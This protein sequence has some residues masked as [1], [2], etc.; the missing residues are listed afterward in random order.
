MRIIACALTLVIGLAH[1]RAETGVG[2]V[3]AGEPTKQATVTSH[4]KAWLRDH[5]YAVVA[6]PFDGEAS[7]TFVN[8][9]VIEDMACARGVFEKRVHAATVIYARVELQAKGSLGLT[10]Y[11]FVKDHDAAA[12]K[13]SCKKCND[14]Q[15]RK[16]IDAALKT[17]VKSSGL[18]KGRLVLSSTPDGVVVEIDTVRVGVTPIERDLEPGSHQI[19]LLQGGQQVGAKAVTIERGETAELTIPVVIP[20]D[21]VPPKPITIEKTKIVEKTKVVVVEKPQPPSRVLP[22]VIMFAGLATAAGGGV[23][24]YYG[25]K[26]GPD[27]PWLYPK[28]TRNGEI[29]AGAGGA[30]FVI[31]TIWF[32]ARSG[33]PQE[34]PPTAPAVTVTPGGATFGWAGVF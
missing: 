10:V 31:G 32:V 6:A 26:K 17:L 9:F 30:L 1:A 34:K 13:E 19:V 24:I 4:L 3:V 14:T 2:I 22:G 11:W 7:T 21:P 8:C 23:S 18:D 16:T 27:E 25:Q 12:D 20:K 28:A 15:L 5:G 33:T 29:L